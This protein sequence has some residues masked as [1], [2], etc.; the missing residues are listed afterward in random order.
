ME[1]ADLGCSWC[2]AVVAT[3]L[4]DDLQYSLSISYQCNIWNMI[5]KCIL[6]VLQCIPFVVSSLSG[7]RRAS[8]VVVI[9]IV[10]IVLLLLL[11]FSSS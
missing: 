7:V 10:V 3:E 5:S 6:D 2:V 4:G 9:V 8:L 1:L 11:L